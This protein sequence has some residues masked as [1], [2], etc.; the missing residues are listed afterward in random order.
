MRSTIFINT[1]EYEKCTL[2]VELSNLFFLQRQALL[3][4]TTVS[5]L[6]NAIINTH[7][8]TTKCVS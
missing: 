6:L 1:Q 3:T 4:G 7:K 8:E 2:L 5:E